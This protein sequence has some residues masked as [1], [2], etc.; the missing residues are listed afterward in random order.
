MHTPKLISS[1]QALLD[2]RN[3]LTNTGTGLGAIAFAWLLGN[4]RA[5]AAGTAH[6]PHFPAKAKRVIHIFSPG[7]MSH[8]DTFDYKPE[9]EKADGK[10]LEGKG[11]L[12]TFFGKPGMLRKS[13]Y[14][15]KQ[16]GQS[17]AWVSDLFPHLSTCV[18]DMAIIRSMVAKSPAHQPACYQMNTGFTLAGFPSLGGWLSYGLGCESDNLPTFVVLPDPRGLVN[19][20]SANWSNGFLPAE[21]QGTVLDT[22]ADNL[23]ADLKTPA[24]I[25]P[26]AR[27]ASLGLL[28][29]L[30]RAYAA[31]DP[32]DTSLH[33]RLG[34]YEL[35]TRMQSSI[36]ETVDFRDES[37]ATSALYGLDH[38]VIGPT[39]RNFLLAR[40]LVERGVRFVQ[41]YNGGALGSPR[42]NWDG[43]E[44]VKENHDRQ[45]QLLDQPCAALLKDLKQ[46]GMLNDTLV[47]WSTEFGRTPFTQGD[48]NS[49]GR[50]H[51]QHTF[52][53]WLAGAG[54]KPG[55]RFGTSDEVGYK[56]AE[57]PVTVY[58]FHATILHILG[59]DHEKLTFYHN[60]INRRLTDVHGKVVN[61]LL[62]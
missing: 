41:V 36:P 26:A 25:T 44:N 52:T 57:N 33:A 38:P 17:G 46:R 51:H 32:A 40:R 13:V 35:A 1:S 12:D 56:A 8:V 11:Q 7:G 61:G 37:P 62:A 2:R 3:F 9:L 42:I 39:A 22:S 14:G 59:L 6:A 20:G 23:V 47:I 5:Q 43:H 27:T 30:N 54:V 28:A 15:F 48:K 21:H 50:D 60:G 10:S 58:D 24:Q 18:D 49:L 31:E 34:S 29:Q 16:Y 4:G 53:C 19:G 55:I 45:G